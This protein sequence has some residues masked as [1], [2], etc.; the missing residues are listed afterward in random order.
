MKKVEFKPPAGVVPEGTQSGSTFEEISTYRVKKNGDI[1]LI[2][3]GE[4]Q[5]PGYSDKDYGDNKVMAAAGKM[6][7]RYP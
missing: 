6:D 2:A 3:I 4:A 1:C 7:E 5:M